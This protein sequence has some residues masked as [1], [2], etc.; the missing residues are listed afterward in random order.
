VIGTDGRQL[1]EGAIILADGSL[2]VVSRRNPG[3]RRLGGCVREG[4]PEARQQGQ[5]P[6]AA[7]T[8]WERKK[9][10]EWVV[11]ARPTRQNKLIKQ[12]NSATSLFGSGKLVATCRD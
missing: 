11:V 4:K 2:A 7:E 12:K 9:W 1:T 3:G 8:G 10:R 6:G 5:D